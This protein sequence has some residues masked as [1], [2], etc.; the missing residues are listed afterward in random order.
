[1]KESSKAV[2]GAAIFWGVVLFCLGGASGSLTMKW[3]HD[4]E[5]RTLRAQTHELA[6]SSK[7]CC[8]AAYVAIKYRPECSASPAGGVK[9]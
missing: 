6:S 2:L 3:A 4:D 8:D 7:V 1:M 9:P 5:L